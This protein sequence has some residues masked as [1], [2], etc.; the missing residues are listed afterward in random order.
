MATIPATKFK[1]QCLVLMDRV[2]ER[3]ESFTITKRGRA[4][5]RLVPVTR[6]QTEPLFGRLRD[7][8]EELGDIVDPV[9]TS[10]SWNALE[11][12]NELETPPHARRTA[13]KSARKSRRRK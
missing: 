10:G 11:A 7:V 6:K 2:S 12:R 1:A 9:T 8:V 5:A 4:V 13:S 3:R